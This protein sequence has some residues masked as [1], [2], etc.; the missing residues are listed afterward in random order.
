MPV[1]KEVIEKFPVMLRDKLE[2]KEIDF[3]KDTEFYYDDICAYRCVT[4]KKDDY[5]KV[6]RA[7]FQ[8]NAEIGRKVIKGE[9]GD[10]EKKPEY[11]GVSLYQD[12]EELIIRLHL[13]KKNRKIVKGS[14]CQ[15]GGPILRGQNTHVC[16]WLYANADVSG[17]EIESAEE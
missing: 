6:T 2:G 10:L 15:H 1:A 4:R 5:S 9:T 12:K 11:Y 3:P 13:P 8:S 16:W 14:I 7:D 17:F